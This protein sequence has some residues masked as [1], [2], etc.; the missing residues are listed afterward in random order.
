ML[1]ALKDQ[2][3]RLSR[4]PQDRFAATVAERLNFPS[5][6]EPVDQLR[7]FILTMPLMISRIRVWAE[8]E[9][10]PSQVRQLHGFLLTYLYHPADLVSE[11]SQGF[12]GYLDDAYLVGCVYSFTTP[13]V[14]Q[15]SSPATHD[16]SQN[17]DAQ[18][19]AWLSLTRRVLPN[20]TKLIDNMLDEIMAGKRNLFEQIMAQSLNPVGQRTRGKD[21]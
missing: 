1:R 10:I 18:I 9:S 21:S 12:I 5:R 13:L 11:E 15:L 6:P 20:E 4:D 16:D 7:S 8:D 17:L 3:V 2:L 19:P 14:R